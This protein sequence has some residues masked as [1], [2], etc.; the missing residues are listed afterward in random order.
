[1]IRTNVTVFFWID[2]STLCTFD[3]R[4]FNKSG[5]LRGSLK[6]LTP[7][8]VAAVMATTKSNAVD[9]FTSDKPGR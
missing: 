7:G 4:A 6:K 5:F 9:H 1:M 8:D 3:S 2:G